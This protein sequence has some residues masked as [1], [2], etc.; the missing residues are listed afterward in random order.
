MD[1]TWYLSSHMQ[2]TFAYTYQRI[3][4]PGQI[5]SINPFVETFA[6]GVTSTN[7]FLWTNLSVEF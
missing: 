7:H 4:N 6:S 5:T 2:F 3:Q 1:L